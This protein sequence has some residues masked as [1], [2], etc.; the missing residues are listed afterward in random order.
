MRPKQTHSLS[1]K[2]WPIWQ[3][4]RIFVVVSLVLLIAG[5]M[6]AV[7]GRWLVISQIRCFIVDQEINQADCLPQ[8]KLLGKSLLFTRF[9]EV[10][11]LG[12]L[13]AVTVPDK[14]IYFTHF[15][16]QLPNTLLLYYAISEPI[17]TVSFDQQ[18]WYVVNANGQLKQVAEKPSLPEVFWSQSFTA[19]DITGGTI[20]T[21]KHQWLL[22][23]LDAA[24]QNNRPISYIGLDSAEQIS[25]VLT[26]SRRILLTIDSDPSVELER[27]ELIEQEIVA[28]PRT[29]QKKVVEIDL[30]F[31]FPVIR[32]K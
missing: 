11:V 31:R 1:A 14:L 32:E 3:V 24:R 2:R 9:D 20:P 13:Q 26:D 5:M 22:R 21:K 17:Y 19:F 12:E 7:F 6:Y 18:Q 23:W 30:R 4:L 16:K 8:S 27:L 10:E 28:N 15:R 25:V 29:N